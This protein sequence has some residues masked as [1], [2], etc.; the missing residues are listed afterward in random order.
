MDFV[1]YHINSFL[2]VY[3]NNCKETT[4]RELVNELFIYRKCAEKAIHLVK[5]SMYS[6]ICV[7]VF[8]YLKVLSE[9]VAITIKQLLLLKPFWMN[10][11]KNTK[12]TT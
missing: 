6:K 9:I 4:G 5:E 8:I 11:N 2:R 12:S 3:L 7:P 10:F 1:R